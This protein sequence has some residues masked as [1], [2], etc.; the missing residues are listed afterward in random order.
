MKYKPTETDWTPEFDNEIEEDTEDDTK[1]DV[2][3]VEHFDPK[4]C[5]EMIKVCHITNKEGN[6]TG[7]DFNS[8]NSFMKYINNDFCN[9]N[10]L[11]SHLDTGKIQVIGTDFTRR[12]I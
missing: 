6:V 9:F 10:H 7:L 4:K 8:N 11:R 3:V 5:R 2:E 12:M 1:D